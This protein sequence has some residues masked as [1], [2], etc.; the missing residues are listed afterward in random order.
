M[1]VWVLSCS[2]P[3]L[4]DPMDYSPTNFS[5]HR[6]LQA[7]IL[8]QIALCCSRDLCNPEIES[9]SPALE[10]GSLPLSHLESP[11]FRH[12]QY[13][14]CVHRG[15]KS[16]TLMWNGSLS[17]RPTQQSWRARTSDALLLPKLSLL[18]DFVVKLFGELMPS[19]F[20]CVLGIKSL[21]LVSF[22][23]L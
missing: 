5:A 4:W 19:S 3:T 7:R 8:E 9:M 15:I 20:A 13:F 22:V 11:T 17:K 1:H 18:I 21:F 6:I 16:K 14:S 10:V 12:V 2:C 23:H